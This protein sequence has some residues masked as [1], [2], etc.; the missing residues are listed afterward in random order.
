MIQ[1]QYDF[2]QSLVKAMDGVENI[3]PLPKCRSPRPNELASFFDTL[4]EALR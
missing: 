2:C 3:L 1:E 4:M